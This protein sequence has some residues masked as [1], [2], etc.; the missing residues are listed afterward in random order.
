MFFQITIPPREVDHKARFKGWNLDERWNVIERE[1][2]GDHYL[3]TETQT[4]P[5][6][7]Q[8]SI[9]AFVGDDNNKVAVQFVEKNKE[10]VGMDSCSFLLSWF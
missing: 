8:R 10:I 5:K 6:P 1:W 4:E 9:L 7:A 2:K 3:L